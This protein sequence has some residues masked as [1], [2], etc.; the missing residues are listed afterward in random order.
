M[1]EVGGVSTASLDVQEALKRVVRAALVAGGVSRGLHESAKV[2]DKREALFCLYAEECDEENY[3]KLI[4]ALC[5]SHEIPIFKIATK[6]ELGE[7][8]GQCKYDKE[9]QARKIVGCSTA[10]V[11]QWGRGNEEARNVV[12]DYLKKNPS[13]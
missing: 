3:E 11:T 12:L 4:R 5:K 13:S 9:G 1:T 6:A 2:L 7:L 8:V 10:V